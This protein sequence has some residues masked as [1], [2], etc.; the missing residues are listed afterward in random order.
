MS[1]VCAPVVVRSTVSTLCSTLS[2]SALRF[3]VRSVVCFVLQ[4]QLRYVTFRTYFM[5]KLQY[6]CNRS[7]IVVQIRYGN[8]IL[9]S[10]VRAVEGGNMPGHVDVPC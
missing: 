5:D 3:V 6:G 4:A 2:S 7:T 9:I 1:I 10:T 8:F